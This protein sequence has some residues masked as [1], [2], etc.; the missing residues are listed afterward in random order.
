MVSNIVGE[1]R[2]HHTTRPDRIGMRDAVAVL[3]DAL[4][5]RCP[6]CGCGS[7]WRNVDGVP[8]CVACATTFYVRQG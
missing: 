8:M 3:W 2:S 4:P 1:R 5:A 6:Q 7:Y